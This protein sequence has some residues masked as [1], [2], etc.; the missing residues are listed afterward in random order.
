MVARSARENVICAYAA[1]IETGLDALEA[2]QQALEV[3]DVDVRDFVD[4]LAAKLVE[5]HAVQA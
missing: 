2:L 5:Y 3:C 4:D 1:R